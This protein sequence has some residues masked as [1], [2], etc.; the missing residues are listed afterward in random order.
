VKAAKNEF[1]TFLDDDDLYY[2]EHLATLA[3]AARGSNAA[4]WYSDAVSAFIDFD[5]VSPRQSVWEL[6]D[7]AYRFGP[8]YSDEWLAQFNWRPTVAERAARI[9]SLLDGYGWPRER[10]SELV[11]IL[12]DN[13]TLHVDRLQA[14]AATLSGRAREVNAEGA[15]VDAS[16]RAWTHGH[17]ALLAE[18]LNAN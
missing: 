8:L 17:L 15:A 13:L 6:A 4:G 9:G 11:A 12:V 3:N 1:I 2:P 18:A 14:R 7:L 10:R 5:T 16:S